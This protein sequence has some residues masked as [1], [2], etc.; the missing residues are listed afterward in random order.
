MIDNNNKNS[1]NLLKYFLILIL[2]FLLSFLIYGKFAQDF[3]NQIVNSLFHIQK[4]F[5]GDNSSLA[6]W[7]FSSSYITI[8]LLG[9]ISPF[10]ILII[11]IL[12]F[13]KPDWLPDN[14]HYLLKPLDFWI[15]AILILFFFM[16]TSRILS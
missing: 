7:L 9:L 10:V 13:L 2:A 5:L 16:I 3:I 15:N 14:D 8:L 6:T 12:N 11:T 4:T 1:V